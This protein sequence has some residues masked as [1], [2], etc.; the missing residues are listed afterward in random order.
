MPAIGGGVTAAMAGPIVALFGNDVILA[1]GG[2]I[3]GHP[4]GAT[5][6]ARAMIRAIESASSAGASGE[7][8]AGGR[9]ARMTTRSDAL[10]SGVCRRHEGG[11]S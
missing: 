7:T 8:P 1:A 3:Q 9:S 6:G 4:G 2:A 5:V 10:G 11:T